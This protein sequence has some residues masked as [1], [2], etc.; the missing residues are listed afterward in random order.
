LL[1]E[2]DDFYVPF[3]GYATLSGSLAITY[4]PAP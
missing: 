3:A 4:L 1:T 2:F